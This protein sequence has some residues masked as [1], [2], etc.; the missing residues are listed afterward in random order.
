VKGLIFILIVL[1]ALAG[2]TLVLG[3]NPDPPGLDGPC[4]ANG[5]I[6]GRNYDAKNLPDV[7]VV[8]RD[9]SVTYTGTYGDAIPGQERDYTGGGVSVVGPFNQSFRIANWG[10]G[11]TAKTSKSGPYNV[12]LDDR[13]PAGILIPASGNHADVGRPCSGHGT[14]K[15]EGAGDFDSILM[16]VFRGLT[17]FFFLLLLL[18]GRARVRA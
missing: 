6:R 5:T 11:K 3:T 14:L 13:I 18:A 9:F 16:W 10:P 1:V 15:I 8:P 12:N 17:A 2:A 4:S 7:I